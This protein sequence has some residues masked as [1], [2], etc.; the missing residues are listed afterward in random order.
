VLNHD[1]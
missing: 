1:H